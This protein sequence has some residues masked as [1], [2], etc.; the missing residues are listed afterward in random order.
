MGGVGR[1][2]DAGGCS[3]SPRSSGGSCS[4]GTRTVSARWWLVVPIVSVL[5]TTI[6]FYGAHRI[7]APAEPVVVVLAAVGLRRRVGS[8]PATG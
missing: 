8:D 5:V 2:R 7:R 4:A 1:H 6:L 3:R